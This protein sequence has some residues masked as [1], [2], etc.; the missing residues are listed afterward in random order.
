MIETEAFVSDCDCVRKSRFR[1]KLLPFVRAAGD[2]AVRVLV[3]VAEQDD[4]VEDGVDLGIGAV[5]RRRQP[6]DELEHRVDAL[7]LVAVDGGLDEDRNLDVVAGPGRASP[8]P[9]GS[10]SAI[11]RMCCQVWKSLRC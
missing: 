5:R 7:V 4:V 10:V 11:L 2:P 1:S 6:L 3:D 8:G 9:S